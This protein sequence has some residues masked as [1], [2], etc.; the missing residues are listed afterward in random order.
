MDRSS[1]R[2]SW[3]L[4]RDGR[5]AIVSVLLLAAV[6][7]LALASVSAVSA[8]QEKARPKT[9]HVRTLEAINIEGEVIVPQVLFITSRDHPRYHDG[10][11]DRYRQSAYDVGQRVVIPLRIRPVARPV[12]T[13]EQEKP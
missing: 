9:G 1:F 5:L 10:L 13:Q 12:S 11:G 2:R 7:G 6:L 8:E 4:W 3:G